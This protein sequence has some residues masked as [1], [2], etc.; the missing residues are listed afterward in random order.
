M[1]NDN[2]KNE[3]NEIDVSNK[4]LRNEGPKKSSDLESNNE[5]FGKF[6][7]EVA[8][9]LPNKNLCCC[10]IAAVSCAAI[11]CSPVYCVLV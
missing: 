7:H 11:C 2:V 6:V 8:G 9:E 5:D 1:T 3:K 4:H 10:G